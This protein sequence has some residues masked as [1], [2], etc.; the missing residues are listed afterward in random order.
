V[1]AASSGQA[2]AAQVAPGSYISIYGTAL[3]GSGVAGATTIPLPLTLNNTQF[4][5]GG[6]PMP[7]I[8]TSAGQVNALVPQGLAPNATYP[9]VVVRGATRSVPVSLTVAELQPGIY[10]VDQSGSGQGTVTNAVTGIVNSASNPAH[11][12]D[13]LTI[14]CTGLGPLTGPTGQT[15]PADGAAP[16]GD[17]SVLYQT[18]STIT[19]TLGGVPATVSFSGLTPGLVALYQVNIQVPPGITAG[20]AVPLVIRAADPQTGASATSNTV[21]VTVQ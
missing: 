18:T 20:N 11:A 9:L 7:L 4:F 19:A 14:Y 8:Y 15:E 2:P 17:A 12:G 1:N 3:T 16:P 21:T 5:L 6:L 10:S 13:Y